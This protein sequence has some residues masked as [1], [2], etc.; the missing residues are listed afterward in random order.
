MHISVLLKES[1]DQLNLKEDSRVVDA[2]LGYAGHSSEILK[3]ITRGCLFAFD[4]DSYAINSSRER[5]NKIGNNFEI[6]KSNFRYLKQELNKRGIEEVDAV[7][8]R[9]WDIYKELNDKEN[10]KIYATKMNI[11]E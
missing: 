1:V 2:T 8:E 5:L 11:E 9:L 3:R 4:Q 6:I 10:V 7:L